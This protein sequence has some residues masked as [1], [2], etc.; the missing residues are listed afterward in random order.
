MAGWRKVLKTR[1]FQHQAQFGVT[2]SAG[3]QNRGLGV[4]VPPLLPARRGGCGRGAAKPGQKKGRERLT[5]AATGSRKLPSLAARLPDFRG[6]R[7]PK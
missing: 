5:V 2:R 4:R 7:T 3:L 6:E 1:T